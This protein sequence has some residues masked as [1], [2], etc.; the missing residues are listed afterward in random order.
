MGVARWHLR[1]DLDA[2]ILAAFVKKLKVI[3]Q[4]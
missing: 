1:Q 2:G 4:P 3:R